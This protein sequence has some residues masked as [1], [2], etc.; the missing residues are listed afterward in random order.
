MVGAQHQLMEALVM[1]FEALRR[2]ELKFAVCRFGRK[3]VPPR[4]LKMM[5]DPFTF[6]IGE[7]ILEALTFDE[8]RVHARPCSCALSVPRAT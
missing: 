5:D 2:L 1:I 7:L 8:V 6:D 3:A 4:M